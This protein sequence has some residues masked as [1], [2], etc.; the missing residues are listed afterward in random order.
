[1]RKNHY[2]G[3]I[4]LF[5]LLFSISASA[6]IFDD[7]FIGRIRVDIPIAREHFYLE[8]KHLLKPVFPSKI[9]NKII[10]KQPYDVVYDLTENYLTNED[11][12][13]NFPIDLIPK[14]L[15]KYAN[16]PS[17]LHG[18]IKSKSKAS[19]II[20][21]DI[22][23][24]SYRFCDCGKVSFPQGTFP[25]IP[26]RLTYEFKIFRISDDET[27]IEIQLK[28]TDK[29]TIGGD[30]YYHIDESNCSKLLKRITCVSTDVYEMETFDAISKR[31]ELR[32]IITN[33]EKNPE[34]LATDI[35]ILQEEKEK[36]ERKR[37]EEERMRTEEELRIKKEREETER[38]RIEEDKKRE[39]DKR[40]QKESVRIETE[41]KRKIML[42]T[43]VPKCNDTILSLYD[44][45]SRKSVGKN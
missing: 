32:L 45:S 5:L 35:K 31:N 14:D 36:E 9:N 16:K 43:Y 13:F 12:L 18:V 27:S 8:P 28:E 25:I 39:E 37:V 21:I 7:L 4:I 6:G 41:Q 23:N 2:I 33:Y 15:Q 40:K 30:R 26:E 38:R 3:V 42:Q 11:I 29:C 17:S 24:A 22:Y 44:G 19:G 1:M 10:I 34:K 20:Q